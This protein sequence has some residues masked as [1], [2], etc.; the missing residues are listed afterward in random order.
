MF[1]AEQLYSRLG[2]KHL[3]ALDGVRM[4]A[5][6]LVIFFHF[7]LTGVP[8]GHGVMIFFVLSGFLNSRKICTSSPQTS[9]GM[10]SPTR[11]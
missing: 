2:N 6:F 7:G 11:L 5:V 3:P 4:L 8:G 1:G 10:W 9:S